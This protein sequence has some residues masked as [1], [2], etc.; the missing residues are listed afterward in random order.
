VLG[1]RIIG[2]IQADLFVGDFREFVCDGSFFAQ[3]GLAH[4]FNHAAAL[5]LK[6]LGI[7]IPAEYLKPSSDDDRSAIRLFMED[8]KSHLSTKP[9]L[10][11]VTLILEDLKD[12][13]RYQEAFWRVFP[14]DS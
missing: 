6:H 9:P 8:L 4:G 11:R 1:I 7:V 3:E 5:G 2:D 12:Y 14:E 10:R 13:K